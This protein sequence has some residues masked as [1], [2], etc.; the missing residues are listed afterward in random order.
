LKMW[1]RRIEKAKELKASIP[2]PCV[3]LNALDTITYNAVHKDPRRAFRVNAAREAL[4]VDTNTTEETVS[5]IALRIE[6][7]IE[8][9]I[10]GTWTTVGPKIKQIKGTPKGDKGKD[11]KGKGKDG[12]GK[13]GKGKLKEPCHYFAETEDGRNKGQQRTRYHRTLKPEEKRCYVCGSTKHMANVCDR[14]KKD[15]PPA[16]SGKDGKGGKGKP[17]GGKDGKGNPLIKQLGE[18]P[19]VNATER[20]L[21]KKE[22]D[23]KE[24]EP[25][26]QKELSELEKK[27]IKTMRERQELLESQSNP[28][29]LESLVDAL[30]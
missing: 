1:K 29:D 11:G 7:E 30:S 25:E 6:G 20:E 19:E 8:D 5:Q 27:V 17:K 2:D 4:A 15:D 14:P 9:S 16:K 22:S 10:T 3:L 21:R 18:V 26:Q 23:P 28:E 24:P 13:D 12:K